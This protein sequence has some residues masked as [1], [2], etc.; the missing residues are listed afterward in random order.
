MQHALSLLDFTMSFEEGGDF[1]THED[2]GFVGHHVLLLGDVEGD[3]VV[4]GFE[5]FFVFQGDGA[6]ECHSAGGWGFCFGVVAQA[7]LD[8]LRSTVADGDGG[9]DDDM[10]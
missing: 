9:V 2:A 7:E 5:D 4:S 8:D 6:I 3:I 1:S 10:D